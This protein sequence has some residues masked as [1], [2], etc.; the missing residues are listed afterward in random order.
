MLQFTISQDPDQKRSTLCALLE[1]HYAYERMSAAR[2]VCMHLLVLVGVLVWLGA[3]WPSFL[4]AQAQAFAD[5]LW[6]ILLFIV[7][8]AGAEEWKWYRRR[9]RYLAER[10][11][12]SPIASAIALDRQFGRPA[13]IARQDQQR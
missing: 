4:P 3:C 1:A 2:S 9:A 11:M 13:A 10:S 6:G 7:V 8:L 12:P 5:E